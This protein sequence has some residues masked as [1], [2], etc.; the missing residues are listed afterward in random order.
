MHSWLCGIKKRKELV[1]DKL[2]STVLSDSCDSFL[3][4]MSHNYC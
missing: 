2:E 3:S 1:L 4:E